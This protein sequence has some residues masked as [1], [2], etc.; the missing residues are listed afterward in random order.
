MPCR[1]TSFIADV[2]AA[3]EATDHAVI[4]IQVNPADL[5]LIKSSEEFKDARIWTATLCEDIAVEVGT[6]GAIGMRVGVREA[7]LQFST[8]TIPPLAPVETPFEGLR[9]TAW[10]RLLE[11]DLE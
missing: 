7:P 2:F 3:V 6:V 9:R 8:Y 5:P 4:G 11:D 10:E 1:I